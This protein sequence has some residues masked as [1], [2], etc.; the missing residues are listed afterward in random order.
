MTI[1]QLAGLIEFPLQRPDATVAD[2]EQHCASARHHHFGAVVVGSA[3][4]GHAR[5]FLEESSVKVV[6]AIGF[7]FGIADSDTKRYETEVAVDNGAQEIEVVMNLGRFKSGE[8]AATLRE[9]RDVAEAADERI[10]KVVLDTSLLAPDDS[11]RAA[12]LVLDS[13][14]HFVC[15]ARAFGVGRAMVEDV[16][17]LREA[18]GPEFGVSVSGVIEEFALA[19]KLVEA[20]AGRLAT[21]RGVALM[22]GTSNVPGRA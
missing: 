4:V 7:P 6:A 12:Q 19:A 20:G 9:L 10:V 17:L 21:A 2:L 16:Q 14:A 15:A 18:V 5:H 3:Y 1:A 22:G 8:D 11:R 13:G